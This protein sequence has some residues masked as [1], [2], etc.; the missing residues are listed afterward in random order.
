MTGLRRALG[1]AR[2]LAKRVVAGEFWLETVW[3]RDGMGPVVQ[4]RSRDPEIQH[5]RNGAG[6]LNHRRYRVHIADA[7]LSAESLA[8]TFRMNPDRFSPHSFATFDLD[9]SASGLQVGDHATV[10][11]P[12]P[13]D[14]P[15]T[16]VESE[17]TSCRLETRDGHMEAGWIEFSTREEGDELVFEIESLARS[18]DAVFDALYHP[19]HVAKIVQSEMW[20]RVLE[21][22]VV[23]S[24][25]RL[26]GRPLIDSTIYRGANG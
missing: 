2:S 18:G 20:V 4:M 10:R 1:P 19:G 21:A 22:A 6:P 25:G 8:Q 26:V 24:G 15:V 5:P 11:L 12:G 3:E 14:G 23:V 13:W 17:P 7:G 16:V 9:P